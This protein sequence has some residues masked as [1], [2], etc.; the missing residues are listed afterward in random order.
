MMR[1]LIIGPVPKKYGG[2]SFGGIATHIEGL[3]KELS[4]LDHEVFLWYH[5]PLKS[6]KSGNVIIEG[7][8]LWK[9]GQFLPRFK[10]FSKGKFNYLSFKQKWILSFQY[11]RLKRILSKTDFDV[12]H[13]HSLH[14]TSS[15]ALQEIDNVSTSYVITDHGFWNHNDIILNNEKGKIKLKN[16]IRGASKIIYISD[17]AEQKHEEIDLDQNGKLVKIKNPLQIV[18]KIPIRKTNKKK[19]VFFNGLTKSIEIK[20]L[21]ILLNAI[22]ISPML[23]NSIELL[24]VANK[25]GL[26]YIKE[27]S[28]NF[29]IRAYGKSTWPQIANFYASSDILVVPS[30]S[31]S[32]GLVYLEALMFGIPIIGLSTLINE[33]Q[34]DFGTYIGEGIDSNHETET[35]LAEK[36]LKVFDSEFDP[37]KI[38]DLLEKKYGWNNNIQKFIATYERAN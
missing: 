20:N 38:L 34:N 12:I 9:L 6:S 31:D 23:Y 28:W 8:S 2:S 4:D 36:I 30:K 1:I 16:A 15:I 13:I 21:P 27:R 32:F 33:F 35:D 10:F 26:D 11:N 14:N 5:K 7:N 17:L 25:A 19:V 22:E 3:S 29:E 24:V 18:R 37:Q